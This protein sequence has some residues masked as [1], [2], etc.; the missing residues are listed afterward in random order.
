MNSTYFF[1]YPHDTIYNK[2]SRSF[3][4]GIQ[5]TNWLSL[6]MQMERMLIHPNED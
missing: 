1:P 3:Y 6:I 4:R 2:R 5:I